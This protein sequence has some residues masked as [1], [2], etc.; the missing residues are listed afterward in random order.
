MRP[1]P[2]LSAKEQTVN[3]PTSR[4][5]AAFEARA[6]SYEHGWL[7]QLH[8]E[9]ADRTVELVLT[10]EPVARRILD[11]GCGTGYLLGVLANRLPDADKLEGIDPALSMIAVASESRG[12]GRLHFS[13]GVAEHLVY[14]DATFDLVVTTTSFDHWTDQLAGLRE[15]RRVLAPGGR[16]VLVDQV[17]LWLV[18]TLL[19]GR[20][21]K[22]RTKSRC[23]RLLR[24]AGFDSRTWNDLYAV[25]IKAVVATI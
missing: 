18:P 23:D 22:A 9:I 10:T 6:L 3:A 15:C 16:L 21:G 24:R 25:I 2:S 1:C 13:V 5:V 20:R 7:G 4:D 17:S 8:H 12:D 14:P 19:V 11:V